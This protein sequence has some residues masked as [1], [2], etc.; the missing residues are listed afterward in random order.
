MV[1]DSLIW[2]WIPSLNPGFE[3]T[4]NNTI[5]SPEDPDG[6][7]VAVTEHG[8]DVTYNGSK[9]HVKVIRNL[10]VFEE[11]S[12][13]EGI[14]AKADPDHYESEKPLFNNQVVY[15]SIKRLYH[16]DVTHDR[17]Q[18]LRCVMADDFRTALVRILKQFIPQDEWSEV[19]KRYNNPP[20]KASTIVH[21]IALIRYGQA[22]LDTYSDVLPRNTVSRYRDYFDANMQLLETMAR[23]IHDEH[24]GRLSR[25]N[26]EL[27]E[28]V[29]RMTNTVIALTYI[30]A[31]FGSYTIISAIDFFDFM[32]P[33]YVL[34]IAILPAA[35]YLGHRRHIRR[36]RDASVKLNRDKRRQA[37]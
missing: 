30:S 7:T 4:T 18:G 14:A 35:A 13:T 11:L 1:G 32:E 28:S 5:T 8:F 37:R 19:G 6:V 25:S 33:W 31:V 27:S 9:T 16:I 2:G 15:E 22:F 24:Y 26:Y 3:A 10:I 36:I 20:P 17:S 23:Y 29:E 12:E 34:I 21:R